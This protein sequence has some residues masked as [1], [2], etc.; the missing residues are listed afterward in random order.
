[1]NIASLNERSRIW[2][3]VALHIWHRTLKWMHGGP[4]FRMQPFSA[5]PSRL[6]IAPQDL[7]TAD[8]TNA[9]D[10]YGGRFL[11]SGHLVETQGRSPFELDA[12][13]EDWQRELHSFGWLR[14]LRA[15][16][17]IDAPRHFWCADLADALQRRGY[18]L[19]SVVSAA[20]SAGQGDAFGGRA[21]F[22]GP[23]G[24]IEIE[25]QG[26]AWRLVSGGPGHDGH[27]LDRPFE[28]ESAFTDALSGFL[29]SQ[30]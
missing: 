2:R 18:R 11:F 26:G 22:T 14:D 8:E 27:G 25:R 1:M 23:L 17:L 16:F 3:L 13:H 21:R 29:L 24:P 4:I 5:V 20:R 7:R 19:A 10:I 28:D 9:A 15:S 6:L 12:V 30:Q